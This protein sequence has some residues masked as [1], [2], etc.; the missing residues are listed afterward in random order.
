MGIHIKILNDAQNAALKAALSEMEGE[1][2]TFAVSEAAKLAALAAAKYP[3]LVAAFKAAF[4]EVET[5]TATTG[6]AKMEKAVA[7]VL[8]Q[9]PAIATELAD[10]PSLK[11]FLIQCG[12]TIFTDGLSELETAAE[13]LVEKLLAAV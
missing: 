13:T 8:P 4:A 9:V 2:K 7:I 6:L 3:A 12:Q 5:D 1:A 10:L 11:D